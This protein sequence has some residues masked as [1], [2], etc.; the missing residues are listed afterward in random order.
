MYCGRLE[1]GLRV[2]VDVLNH[3]RPIDELRLAG[4]RFVAICSQYHPNARSAS[5][6][7]TESGHTTELLDCRDQE[8]YLGSFP[9]DPW[10]PTPPQQLRVRLYAR[11]DDP[12]NSIRCRRVRCSIACYSSSSR[13]LSSSTLYSRLRITFLCPIRILRQESGGIVVCEK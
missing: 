7:L 3:E 12:V 10:S 1:S 13:R 4:K 9:A 5:P 2:R 6:L 11:Y 8:E